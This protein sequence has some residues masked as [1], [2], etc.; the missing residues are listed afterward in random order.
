MAANAVVT[1]PETRSG[2]DDVLVMF[3]RVRLG[4]AL[5]QVVMSLYLRQCV[6]AGTDCL[7]SACTSTQ[8]RL[9]PSRKQ[10]EILHLTFPNYQSA[11]TLAL[12][13]LDRPS[14]SRAVLEEFGPPKGS[15]RFRERRF[16]TIG[17]LMPK[18]PVNENSLLSGRKDKVRT[19]RQITTMQAK[20]ISEGMRK[21]PNYSLGLRVLSANA[22]HKPTAFRGY[23]GLSFLC[24]TRCAIGFQRRQHIQS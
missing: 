1:I 15:P 3:Y 8:K 6:I 21:T 24:G 13:C 14:V 10:R 2:L 5:G 11:P 22:C 18:T 12:Q 9:Q 7:S 19:A 16:S 23:R 20:S 17:M 4:T